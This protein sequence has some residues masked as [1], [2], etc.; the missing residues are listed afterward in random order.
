MIPAHRRRRRRR[1]HNSS[2]VSRGAAAAAACSITRHIPGCLV[3]YAQSGRRQGR[4]EIV[5]C[6]CSTWAGD[7]IS[8]LSGIETDE[9]IKFIKVE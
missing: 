9:L 4:G 6:Y 2:V 7:V 3:D 1:Y 5:F 8:E